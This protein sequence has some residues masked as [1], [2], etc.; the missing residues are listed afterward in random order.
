M[1]F[2]KI[3][4]HRR[5]LCLRPGEER[6]RGKIYAIYLFNRTAVQALDGLRFL[7]ELTESKEKKGG[8]P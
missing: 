2:I 6:C 4:R 7:Q 5:R 1:Q 8:R 3:F